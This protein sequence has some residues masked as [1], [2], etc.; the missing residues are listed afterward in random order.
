MKDILQKI[1]MLKVGALNS[2]YPVYAQYLNSQDGLLQTCNGKE[3]VQVEYDLPFDGLVNIFVLE[4]VL[5]KVEDLEDM[6]MYQDGD[7][8]Y[9]KCEAFKAK[10]NM[11]D[12]NYCKFPY[13]TFKKF[14]SY[15]ILTEELIETI[16]KAFNYIGS[17]I[18]SYVYINNKA[19][20]ASDMQ[21]A[22]MSPVE[23][24]LKFPI[25]VNKTIIPL[26]SPGT[27]LGLSNDNIIVYYDEHNYAIFS[28]LIPIK[29]YPADKLSEFVVLSRSDT[30]LCNM[31]PIMSAI[32]KITA[33]L[34]NEKLKMINFN[35]NGSGIMSVS[36]T[37]EMNGISDY[38][39]N[40][41]NDIDKFNINMDL[42]HINKITSDYYM[43]KS[44]ND[45][46]YFNNGIDE[47]AA[48]GLV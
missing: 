7:K 18:Y 26:L 30:Q 25:G 20:I 42:N 43:Y 32:H 12:R 38:Q 9:I 40:I 28:G 41:G 33:V 10:L 27:K 39:V 47:I 36:T 34:H 21:K 13:L 19:I 44:I 16:E 4:S 48:I 15:V 17:N 31:L 3:F 8:I 37:S 46:L 24:D 35:H 11:L 2:D 6:E 23:L 45:R 14:D 1:Q 29:D 5:S 22:F